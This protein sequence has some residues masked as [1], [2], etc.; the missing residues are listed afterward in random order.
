[1]LGDASIERDLQF[2]HPV[3]EFLDEVNE[4]RR[5]A[6]ADIARLNGLIETGLL[7]RCAKLRG[8]PADAF[9]DAGTFEGRRGGV[10]GGLPGRALP[11]LGPG[12]FG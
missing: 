10:S 9:S 11:A 12:D 8:L 1:M 7:E 6:Q 2:L 5:R 4:Q 3:P